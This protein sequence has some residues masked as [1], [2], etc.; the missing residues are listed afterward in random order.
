[1][2]VI[3]VARRFTILAKMS[4]RKCKRIIIVSLEAGVKKHVYAQQKLTG[5]RIRLLILKRLNSRPPV[6]RGRAGEGP[7]RGPVKGLEE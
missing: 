5:L 1:M 7:G 4:G 3:Y 2:H 6:R